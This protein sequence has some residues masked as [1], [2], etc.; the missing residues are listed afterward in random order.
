MNISAFK[1]AKG[2]FKGVPHQHT[3]QN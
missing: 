2:P 1:F 3:A